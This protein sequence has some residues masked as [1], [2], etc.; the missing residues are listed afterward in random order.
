MLKFKG[1]RRTKT[2]QQKVGF[3]CLGIIVALFFSIVVGAV[4]LFSSCMRTNDQP[5]LKAAIIDQLYLNNPNQSMTEEI[6][7]Y[8]EDYGFQVDIY[9]GNDVTVDFYRNLAQHDYN[10]IIIRSHSG[11]MGYE[12][13]IKR[14]VGTY[15][16]TTESYSTL[17]YPKEQINDEI[18]M[19]SVEPGQPSYFAIGPKFITDSMKGKLN[20][21]VVIIDGC[22]GLYSPDLANAFIV[23][24]A[25]AYLAWDAPVR[26]DYVDGATL[27]LIKNLCSNDVKVAKAV[28]VTMTENGWDPE[29]HAILEY[30]PKDVGNL[31]VRQLTEIK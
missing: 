31:S 27:S 5:T 28:D 4:W 17:K 24:G 8:L 21:T 29:S 25:T 13:D 9:H 22:S 3:L 11:A 2:R 20:N 23:K 14:S 1:N 19:A 10:L 18:A 6:T 15:L 12:P 26:L 16:F 7:Q 30:Y